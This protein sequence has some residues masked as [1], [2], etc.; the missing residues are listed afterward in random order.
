[1]TDIDVLDTL[2]VVL[3]DM[4]EFYEDKALFA[5]YN[6]FEAVSIAMKRILANPC[7]DCISR[8]AALSKSKMIRDKDGEWQLVID[9]KDI[10]WM[11]AVTPADK[12]I[13][14]GERLPDKDGEYLVC[15]EQGYA[16]DFD[17]KGVGI[18]PF[19]TETDAFGF[20]RSDF[21]DIPVIAWMPLPERY[22]EGEE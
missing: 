3:D 17:A 22:K 10:E 9:K 1:M 21:N 11:E 20:G 19:N 2:D 6:V 8:D 13:P 4:A 15:Y 12:W 14:V 7:G 5:K 18:T 16:D